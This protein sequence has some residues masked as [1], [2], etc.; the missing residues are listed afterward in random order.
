MRHFMLQIPP[1]EI[2]LKPVPEINASLKVN[3][4]RG[5]LKT[6]RTNI[7]EYRRQ[8]ITLPLLQEHATKAQDN[9][10]VHSQHELKALLKTLKP[11]IAKFQ[12][13]HCPHIQL[14]QVLF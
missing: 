5:H 11:V 4:P 13:G 14:G 10:K 3:E 12:A 7:H 8:H 9:V 2:I 1:Q 6:P